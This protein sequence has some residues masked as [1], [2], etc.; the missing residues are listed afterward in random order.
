MRHLIWILIKKP[1]Y[2]KTFNLIHISRFTYKQIFRTNLPQ[3]EFNQHQRHLHVTPDNKLKRHT[4]TSLAKKQSD[5]EKTNTH[6]SRP[7]QQPPDCR[8]RLS[9]SR[10]VMRARRY[11]S[12]LTLGQQ[13]FTF[14]GRMR[15][16]RAQQLC[17]PSDDN[18]PHCWPTTSIPSTVITLINPRS[19]GWWVAPASLH[20]VGFDGGA[21]FDSGC[22]VWARLG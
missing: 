15:G 1:L 22:V 20:L 16:R 18:R 11:T 5:I 7:P 13:T 4:Q 9:A 3:S 6:T 21:G 2:R 14:V 10:Q 12:A 17:N 19:C 8:Q